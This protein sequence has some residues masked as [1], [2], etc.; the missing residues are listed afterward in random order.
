MRTRKEYLN[1]EINHHD[2]YSQFVTESSKEFIKRSLKVEDI[3]KALDGGDTALNKI[4]IPY[5]NLTTGGGWW[6]DGTPVN[7]EA[8]KS[9]EETDTPATRTCVGKTAARILVENEK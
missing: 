8:L 5:N 7:I 9:C 1:G 2:Y 4:K 6:W 3:K